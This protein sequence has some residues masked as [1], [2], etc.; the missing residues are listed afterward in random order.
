MA[1]WEL[2]CEVV[3]RDL[4]MFRLEDGEYDAVKCLEWANKT[5]DPVVIAVGLCNL[6][7]FFRLR[8]RYDKVPGLYRQALQTVVDEFGENSLPEVIIRNNRGMF[9]RVAGNLPKARAEFRKALEICEGIGCKSGMLL[10]V[11]AFNMGDLLC[12]LQKWQQALGLFKRAKMIAEVSDPDNENE[13]FR[14]RL[15]LGMAR[16]FIARDKFP[17][18]ESLL[19]QALGSF[20]RRLGLQHPWVGECRIYLGDL[21]LRRLAVHNAPPVEALRIRERVEE[22]YEMGIRILSNSLGEYHPCLN[23]G[24][25]KLGRLYEE[26]KE[27]RKAKRCFKRALDILL[28]A[29]GPYHSYV[30]D[31]LEEC[32]TLEQKRGKL[33]KAEDLKQRAQMIRL[34]SS[35]LY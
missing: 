29:F 8:G 15:D 11:V 31:C 33:R 32:A 27:Y 1:R 22:L 6:A 30:A 21:F 18:A 13:M 28:D 20:E 23:F 10:A 12:D 35:S 14:R 7:L 9:F 5:R 24:L 2:A 34:R 16:V 4:D 19:A 26:N 17:R 25:R 3:T